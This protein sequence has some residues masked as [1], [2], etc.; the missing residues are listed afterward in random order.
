MLWLLPVVLKII[1]G[2]LWGSWLL[3]KISHEKSR[4]E[5]FAINYF[6]A[7]VIAGILALY[8]NQFSFNTV[9]FILLIIG[10]LNGFA[11]YCQWRAIDI[12]LSKSYLFNWGYSVIA[13][14]LSFFILD[15][16]KFINI[17]IGLGITVS[18]ISAILF[19]YSGY[20][21]R[22][23]TTDNNKTGSLALYWW[24]LSYS[25]IWGVVIFS[26]KYFAL[27]NVGVFEMMY[28]RY[29]GSLVSVL[30][31]LFFLYLKQGGFADV[32]TRDVISSSALA[33]T[34]MAA[35]AFHYWSLILAPLVIVQ[36][37]FLLGE[38]VIPTLLGVFGFGEG[39]NF[40]R[41]EWFYFW[42]GFLGAI[43]IIYGFLY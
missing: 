25:V 43:L 30:V 27:E 20:R 1:S 17:P 7:A 32:S 28:G 29:W 10:F 3:K 35:F 9:F 14:I 8:F 19:A 37:I 41:K 38:M 24:I 2:D 39:K 12:S 34:V 6:V 23:E 15:E 22:K 36:P 33:I 40:S 42:F 18:L 13:M 5:R 4:I 21:E 26:M 31:L 16:S 11:A